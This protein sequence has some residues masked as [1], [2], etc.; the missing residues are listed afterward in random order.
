LKIG[1]ELEIPEE[2][3]YLIASRSSN[4]LAGLHD[5]VIKAR[6]VGIDHTAMRAALVGAGWAALFVD[7]YLVAAPEPR[8]TVATVVKNPK[9]GAEMI[10][11]PE[12]EFLMGGTAARER[13][14]EKVF[15]DAYRIAKNPVTVAEFMAYCSDKKIDFS[16]F[17][18]P[19]W[20]WIDDHPMVRVNWQEARDFCMWAGGDLPTETQWEKAA[21]GA[22][23]RE[24]PWGNKWDPSRCQCSELAVGDARLTSPVGSY[25]SGASPFGCLDMAG[26]VWEWCQDWYAKGY[27]GQGNRNPTGPQTGASRVMRGG[28][29][30]YRHP[31]NFRCARRK[32]LGPWFHNYDRGFR[33]AG[34]P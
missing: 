8:P 33:P 5:W 15:L 29:W 24:Y 32:H 30:F 21:R 22:D 14:F 19:R 7:W 11:I 12:G 20:G 28:S 9:T 2:L 16:K 31:E 10:L 3:A 4:D 25:P 17:P 23:G 6:A 27:G 1:E 26:N 18:R 34:P 13:P